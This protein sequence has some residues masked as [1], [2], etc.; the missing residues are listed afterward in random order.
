MGREHVGFAASS[1]ALGGVG[2]LVFGAV[3]FV[4]LAYLTQ[5][6]RR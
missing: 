6:G 2:L 5:Q 4:A 1:L 3:L